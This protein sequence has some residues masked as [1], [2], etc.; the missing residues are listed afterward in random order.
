MGLLSGLG[1]WVLVLFS[2]EVL[3]LFGLLWRRTGILFFKR[4]LYRLSWILPL[5]LWLAYLVYDTSLN[6]HAIR[7]FLDYNHFMARVLVRESETLVARFL[8]YLMAGVIALLF[9]PP[10]ASRLK[11]R[12]SG[13]LSQKV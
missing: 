7:S 2:V 4:W 5:H 13:D 11:R 1:Y 10:L 12:W 8:P 6:P 3:I 9:L